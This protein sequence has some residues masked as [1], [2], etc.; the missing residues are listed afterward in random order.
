MKTNE[1]FDEVDILLNKEDF[2]YNSFAQTILERDAS[3]VENFVISILRGAHRAIVEN[4]IEVI[5]DYRT[6]KAILPV[7]E[8]K[9]R[10]LNLIKLYP[11]VF[12]ITQIDE[13]DNIDIK[14]FALS[15]GPE[16]LYLICDINDGTV[17]SRYCYPKI[18]SEEV[19][20]TPQVEYKFNVHTDNCS[21]YIEPKLAEIDPDDDTEIATV[22]EISTTV[23]K[24]GNTPNMMIVEMIPDVGYVFNSV[25]INDTVYYSPEK[26]TDLVG[27]TLSKSSRGYEFVISDV[28]ED[29]DITFNC[30]KD[31]TVISYT[32]SGEYN[33]CTPNKGL[34]FEVVEGDNAS[35]TFTWRSTY[36]IV[37]I[38]V[39][40]ISYTANIKDGIKSIT[41]TYDESSDDKAPGMT[42]E[43]TAT[44]LRVIFNNVQA[45]HFISCFCTVKFLTVSIRGEHV[46]CTPNFFELLYGANTVSS[47]EV[48]NGHRITGVK[49]NGGDALPFDIHDA[50]T[51]KDSTVSHVSDVYAHVF[52]VTEDME[53]ELLTEAIPEEPNDP[54]DPDNPDPNPDDPDNP[55]PNPEDPD[56]PDPNPEDPDGTKYKVT[57]NFGNEV[58]S[59]TTANIYTLSP[60]LDDDNSFEITKGDDVEIT[61]K[62]G[63][64]GAISNYYT[65]INYLTITIGDDDPVLVY[66][67]QPGILTATNRSVLIENDAGISLGE[68]QVSS[69]GN[70]T[71]DPHDIEFTYVVTID[72]VNANATVAVATTNLYIGQ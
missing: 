19:D 30:V 10:I 56:N 44:S 63:Y 2:N 13:F 34:P 42:I 31:E 52:N 45:D 36:E 5:D 49:I 64:C 59:A 54:D 7:N 46:T 65:T 11:S 32:I 24:S 20:D 15:G 21:V 29:T 33:N 40:G 50:V 39:D 69:N 55:D 18:V 72:E 12:H 6:D 1:Y 17:I 4:D 14:V 70:V 27:I 68:V 53:I 23:V 58:A 61:Y 51:W 22:N 71:D 57:T 66:V 60:D 26:V 37:S 38:V 67:P 8:A 25:T 3:A 16:G 35:I 43:L 9:T 28:T 41:R 47:I 62:A 48:L